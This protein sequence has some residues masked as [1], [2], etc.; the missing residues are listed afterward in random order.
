V[1]RARPGKVVKRGQ[2]LKA[3][4]LGIATLISS[5]AVLKKEIK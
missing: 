2:R 4:K 3:V 5:L 1:E